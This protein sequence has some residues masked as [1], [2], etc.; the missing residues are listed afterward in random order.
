LPDSVT[1]QGADDPLAVRL[2]EYVKNGGRLL[3]SG[4]SGMDP[5]GSAFVLDLGLSV[6]GRAAHDPDYLV[7]TAL[8]PTPPV[9]GPFVIHGGA[10]NI[11]SE[12]GTRHEALAHRVPSYFNRAWDH[13]CSHQH[14]PDDSA[15]NGDTP[16]VIAGENFV[17]FAHAVFTAYRQYGQPLYRDLVRDALR[18]LLPD[19]TVTAGGLPTAGRL[20]LMRQA[21]DNRLVLHLLYATPV[22]RGADASVYASGQQAVEVIEDLVP[23][24]GIDCRVRLAKGERARRITLEP[25]G[26]PL[27]FDTEAGAV[28]FTVPHV[29]CHQMISVA[30]EGHSA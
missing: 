14:T 21:D 7:P 29:L 16:A 13:F 30:L 6:S 15:A 2:R 3:L 8:A 18:R 23:L 10:W 22:K 11:A 24:H 12:P 28:R 27:P 1:L 25:Q 5:N 26:E 20:S 9:R 17:C 4:T 19:P